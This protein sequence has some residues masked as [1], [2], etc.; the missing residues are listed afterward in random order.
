MHARARKVSATLRYSGAGFVVTVADDG[1]G[2]PGAVISDD[3]REHH[4]G[5]PG[6]RER[7]A[8]L[9]ATLTLAS[10]PNAGTAWTLHVLARIAFA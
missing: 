10:R 3:D 6:M 2:L 4:W 5:I 1:T 9:G 7:A 8:T